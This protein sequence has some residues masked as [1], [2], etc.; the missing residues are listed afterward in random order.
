MSD[1]VEG[2][3]QAISEARTG[4]SLSWRNFVAEAQAAIAAMQADAAPVAHCGDADVPL[5]SACSVPIVELVQQPGCGAPMP[6]D[7]R[8]STS[9]P[10]DVGETG[11]TSSKLRPASVVA[12]EVCEEM[13]EYG[14]SFATK[15]IEADRQAVRE[16]AEQETVAKIV[17]WLRGNCM[18]GKWRILASEIEEGAW[19]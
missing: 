6:V 10:V 9:S 16:Q 15:V 4:N 18:S 13:E 12:H 14:P 3:A 17:A 1:T 5:C 11:N 2:V 7:D 19:K 8:V